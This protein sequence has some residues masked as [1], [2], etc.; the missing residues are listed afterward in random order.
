MMSK[1][2]TNPNHWLM[3]HRP[4]EIFVGPHTVV[5][6]DMYLFRILLPETPGALGKVATAI[7]NAGANINALEIIDRRSGSAID[8]FIVEL[9]P[10]VMP[11]T[12][13]AS[14]HSVEGVEVLWVSRTYSDWT[15]ASDIEALNSMLA[16][17]GE[18]PAVLVDEAPNLFH[19]SW[20]ALVDKGFH[21]LH[22]TQ[23]APDFTLEAQVALGDLDGVR[24]LDLPPDWIPEWGETIVAIAPVG[25][26]WILVGRQ[27]GPSYLPS[28]LTRL[29]HLA[30]LATA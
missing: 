25:D 15:I 29:R 16:D 14:C 26:Q 28:E 23:A 5:V 21:V 1:D 22:A 17:P 10:D 9:P 3:Y 30:A 18:A 24:S 7:G 8:D 4:R 27:G 12:V 11:D 2:S 13:V 6:S 19:S 20:A